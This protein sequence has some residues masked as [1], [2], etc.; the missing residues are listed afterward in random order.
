MA[1]LDRPTA[2][3]IWFDGQ[4]VTGVPVRRRNVAMV[5][6]QFVNYP[7][8]SVFENIASPLRVAG[9]SK[10][11]IERKV[12]EAAALLKLTPHLSRTPLEL[13]GGQQQRTALARAIVK[14][15][16][17]VLLD[18]PLANL[19]YKL[20]EELREELPRLFART[21]AIL[22][23]ATTEPVEALMLGG[24][25]ATL[26]QGQVTQFGPAAEVFRSPKDL[27]T[28]QTYS[29]PPLN[30]A[31]GQA[32]GLAASTSAAM[33]WPPR[34]WPR[35]TTPSAFAPAPRLRLADEGVP[36][37]RS[38]PPRPAARKASSMSIRPPARLGG[39]RAGR[40]PGRRRRGRASPG[41]RSGP[42][43]G[44]RR[45]RRAGGRLMA[46]ISLDH[47]GHAYTPGVPA[48]KQR[49]TTSS[50]T[51][52]PTRPVLGHPPVAAR[53]PCSTSSRA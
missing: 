12:A 8:M 18:E 23:Y 37:V 31:Q 51:A 41:D 32:G 21:G 29:D 1:G 25:T 38:A 36:G 27:V 10:A 50:R 49:S 19:D 20:R 7:S 43:S 13:S 5:Y 44:L 52:A 4:D 39:H 53:P 33:A 6:Q 16:G 34:P 48:L 35:A 26:S 30:I 47:V 14:G 2:G 24:A 17:L 3:E 22:V 9:A 42:G 46:R 28:A 15:A 11:E 45:P 40:T